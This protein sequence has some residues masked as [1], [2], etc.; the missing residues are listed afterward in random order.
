M[1]DEQRPSKRT[2]VDEGASCAGPSS[3]SSASDSLKRDPDLWFEDGN[4]ILAARD[5][6]F[7]VYRGLLV[8]QSTV[9]ADM[10]ATGNPA[11]DENLDGCPVVRLPDAPS[12]LKHLL[13]FL[14]PSSGRTLLDRK[15]PIA[16]PAL[17][18]VVRLA[19]K[20]NIEDLLDQA[21]HILKL[22]YTT[23]FRE[24][25]HK[26][27]SHVNFVPPALAHHV[28]AVNLAR[29]TNTPSILPLA[30]YHCCG[31]SG[32]VMDGWTR[33]TGETEYLS[34][35]DLRAVITGR[36]G[37]TQKGFTM[38][39]NIFDDDPAPGC[40]Q[41][42]L[43]GISLN[44]LIRTVGWE[45]GGKYDVL[46]SWEPVIRRFAKE[47]D[48]CKQCRNALLKRE[49]MERREVWSNLP[50][51]FELSKVECQWNTPGYGKSSSDI[52][53]DY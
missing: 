8:K 36:D 11:A 25:E 35:Q 24:F 48:M 44:G 42:A 5:V 40:S 20:Y 45:G 26:A 17:F 30:L 3:T 39:L 46:D 32:R 15:R 52:D 47:L 22:F 21:L 19:H 49:V 28:G 34:T 13:L 43:C 31:L 53:S 12:D 37:L 38:L 6:A 18:A 27:Y 9:F 41:R 4:I 10:F 23:S 29:L 33:E 7:R 2:R 1:P 50:F 14:V 16:F 51:M